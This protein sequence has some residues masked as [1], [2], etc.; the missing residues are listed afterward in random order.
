MK[1]GILVENHK[2]LDELLDFVSEIRKKN[3]VKVT[4]FS[5]DNFYKDKT[6]AAI[7][8][9]RSKEIDETFSIPYE[10]E[11]PY[12]F[13]NVFKKLKYAML[14]TFE[15]RKAFKECDFVLVGIQ[16][17][18]VR[19]LYAIF[20]GKKRIFT[21]HRHFLT[22]IDIPGHQFDTFFWKCIL[23]PLR[24]LNLERLF[25]SPSGVGFAHHYF[26]SGE[27]N[28][29]YLELEGVASNRIS[30]IGT[31]EVYSSLTNSK[32]T[33]PGNAICYI[34]SGYEWYGDMESDRDQI[35]HIEK[36]VA[37]WPDIVIRPHPR[38]KTEKYS[39]FLGINGATL[40]FGDGR[41]VLDQLQSF[42]VL[43]G[44]FSTLMFEQAIVGKTVIFLADSKQQHLYRKFLLHYD[45]PVYIDSHSV[46]EKLSDFLDDASLLKTYKEKVLAVAKH[47][48][49]FDPL[50]DPKKVF[51]QEISEILEL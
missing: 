39:R 13:L 8:K 31:P 6:S 26:V 22:H 5:S 45:L 44:A 43:L 17:I 24:M 47:V 19:I 18:F 4:L 23:F 41:P 28:K 33:P 10:E 30:I 37:R 16:T 32:N 38:E 21:Y 46:N 14:A 3:P 1:I 48:V 12:S 40:Q 36:I 15:M 20:L 50:K 2:E 51:A 11:V 35:A 29:K 27:C 9:E 42:N 7:R 25:A 49:F 34:C